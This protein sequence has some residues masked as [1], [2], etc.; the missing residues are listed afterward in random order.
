MYTG[1]IPLFCL[2][3]FMFGVVMYYNAGVMAI[4][5]SD[6]VSRTVHMNTHSHN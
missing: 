1:S 4:I 3:S 2:N 5:E 6:T